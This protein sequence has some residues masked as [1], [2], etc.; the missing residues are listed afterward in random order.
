MSM[1]AADWT[2]LQARKAGN[3][4]VLKAQ[5]S[6][7]VSPTAPRVPPYGTALLI[8]RDVGGPKT[9]RPASDFTNYTA[10]QVSDFVLYSQGSAAGTRNT[11]FNTGAVKKTLNRICAGPTGCAPTDLPVKLTASE[12]GTVGQRNRLT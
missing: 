6:K 3:T 12:V 4:Y 7:E 10:S 9:V 1:S 11:A 2:R 5:N 8:P